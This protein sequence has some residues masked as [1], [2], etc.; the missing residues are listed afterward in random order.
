MGGAPGAWGRWR[1]ALYRFHADT[2]AALLRSTGVDDATAERV[3]EL[4]AKRVPRTDPDSQALEDGLCLVFLEDQFADLAAKVEREKMITIL[5]KT[6]RKMSPAAQTI[7]LSLRLSEAE[8][9]LVRAALNAD[10]T[11]TADD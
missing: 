11:P 6:W 10:S 7:A 4:V 2:A 8:G 9:E 3:R 5:R 1:T